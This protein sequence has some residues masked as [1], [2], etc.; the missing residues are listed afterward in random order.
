MRVAVNAEQLLQPSPGGIGRYTAR[1][2]TLLGT[3]EPHDE[4][5]TFVARHRADA[6]AAAWTQSGLADPPA[7]ALPAVLALPRPLLYDLWHVLGFPPLSRQHR[8]LADA[9]AH[10]RAVAGRSSAGTSPLGGERP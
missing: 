4:V 5:I 9:A 7:V 1:L 6:V 2:V 8:D 3:E 10:P